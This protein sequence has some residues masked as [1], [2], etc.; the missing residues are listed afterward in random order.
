[1]RQFNRDL[2]LLHICWEMSESDQGDG[3]QGPLGVAH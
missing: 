2:N 3:T 1:M